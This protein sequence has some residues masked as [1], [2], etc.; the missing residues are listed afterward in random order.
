MTESLY[1][2][3]SQVVRLVYNGR[4][5]DAR[6]F[7]ANLNELDAVDVSKFVEILAQIVREEIG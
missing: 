1:N 7:L 4:T 2:Y 6:V 5:S 3:L